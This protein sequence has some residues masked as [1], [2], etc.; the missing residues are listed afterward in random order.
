MKNQSE[1]D[2]AARDQICDDYVSPKNYKNIGGCKFNN[3][4]MKIRD[5]LSNKRK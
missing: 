5:K 2:P 3:L 1:A 4:G